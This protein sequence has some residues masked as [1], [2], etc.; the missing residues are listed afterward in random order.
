MT[1]SQKQ[2][3]ELRNQGMSRKDIAETMGRSVSSVR[4]LLE[5]ARK[6]VDPA[7]QEAMKAVGTNLV[8]RVMWA[9]THKDGSTTYSALLSEEG[10]DK[11][12]IDRVKEAFTDI[13]AAPV[14]PAPSVNANEFLTIYP[15]MDSHFGMR[16]WSKATAYQD[17]D[18]ELAAKDMKD[19]FD[20]VLPFSLKG[21]DAVIILGGD[22]LHC[23][24]GTNETP[25]SG[26]KLD[27]DGRFVHAADVA[28]NAISHAIDRLLA[29]HRIVRVRVLRG[30]H[31]PSAHIILWAA[32]KQR[33]RNNP[34]LIV[35]D[36]ERDLYSI[37]WGRSL[38]AAHHGD[39]GFNPNKLALHIADTVPY[40]SKCKDR[41]A[42]TGHIHHDSMKDLGGIKWWSLRAFCP[43]DEYGSG[44]TSRRALQVL[45]FS[46][47]KGHVNTRIEPILRTENA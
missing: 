44:F 37:E 11:S 47:I 33:Y 38:I 42:L 43:P 16:A 15:V 14:V 9:K 5:R 6:K 13:P 4:M 22:T 26:H 8:P 32:F 10:E 7:T 20:D 3:L 24:D 31:D 25:A 18:L 2:A 46:K 41:H 39:R 19:A 1:P 40:W 21:S 27:V 23:D 28:V 12:L 34:R 35:E 29:H 17:Y 30:N 36:I 45:T